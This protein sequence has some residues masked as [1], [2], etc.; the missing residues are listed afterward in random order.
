MSELGKEFSRKKAM[1]RTHWLK[2]IPP[3][4]TL[5]KIATNH[6]SFSSLDSRAITC[7]RTGLLVFKNWC[8]FKIQKKYRGD[9]K[10]F[11][12]PCPEEDSL[13][14]VM[15]CQFYSTKFY[16]GGEGP[17]RDWANFLVSLN[18]ERMKNFNQPL[19]WCEGWSPEY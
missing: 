13:K 7:L 2:K 17:V 1:K 18:R 14:H 11:Y 10:C 3:M 8:P 4:L 6:Y 5:E 19:I 15:E 16:E 12:D 9:K